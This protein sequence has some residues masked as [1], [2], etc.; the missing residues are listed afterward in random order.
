VQGLHPKAIPIKTRIVNGGQGPVLAY[1][2]YFVACRNGEYL[3]P[4]VR[5][6]EKPPTSA[7]AVDV[8]ARWVI[9]GTVE[10]ATRPLV[11]DGKL[12]TPILWLL[13]DMT[14]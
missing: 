10:G 3:W 8:N 4:L 12:T 13:V 6:L 1:G 2:C 9:A 7:L 5:L 11:A 14:D